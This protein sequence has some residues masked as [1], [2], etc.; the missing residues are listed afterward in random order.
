MEGQSSAWMN[1]RSLGRSLSRKTSQALHDH[2]LPKQTV[3]SILPTFQAESADA[4][5][6][7]CR[8]RASDQR[9]SLLRDF[10]SGLVVCFD[11]DSALTSRSLPDLSFIRSLSMFCRLLRPSF[12]QSSS[13]P[14]YHHVPTVN[15]LPIDNLRDLVFLFIFDRTLF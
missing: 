3:H 8:L 11:A 5:T 6:S 10:R 14:S 7:P 1:V 12:L 9:W 2:S 15:R 13:A 4:A